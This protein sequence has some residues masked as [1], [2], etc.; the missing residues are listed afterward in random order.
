MDN[1]TSKL[2]TQIDEIAKTL[3]KLNEQVT[4]LRRKAHGENPVRDVLAHFAECWQERYAARYTF[5]PR[6]DPA[7]AKRLLKQ[8]DAVT[9]NARITRYL[10]DADPFLI[11]AAHPFGLFVSKMNAYAASPLL[12]AHPIYCEHTPRCTSAVDCTRRSVWESRA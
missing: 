2:L 4:A 11:H 1:D 6:V 12:T 5:N 7:Q 8:L 3:A 10:K 9:L